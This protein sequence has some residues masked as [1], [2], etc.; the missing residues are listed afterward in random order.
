M[1]HL[2]SAWEAAKANIQSAQKKQKLYYDQKSKETSFNVGDCVLVSMPNEVKGKS[3]KLSRPFHGP[4]HI[5]SLTDCNAAVKLS[6][7]KDEPIFVSLDRVRP[8]PSELSNDVCWTGRNTKRRKRQKS[9]R[10]S[11]QVKERAPVRTVGPVTR[12]MTHSVKIQ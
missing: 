3:W 1:S 12:S 11:C 4:Y 5:V 2:G 7:G 10:K 6:D 8:C 9:Q